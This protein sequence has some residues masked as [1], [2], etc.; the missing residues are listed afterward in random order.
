MTRV[1]CAM[2]LAASLLVLTP[3]LFAQSVTGPSV[4]TERFQSWIVSCVATSD[5]QDCE[6]IQNIADQ[7]GRPIM[8]LHVSRLKAD[9]PELSM[10]ARFPVNIMTTMPIVWSAGE[11]SVVLSLQICLNTI[12]TAL[13]H[14][15]EDVAA[16]LLR[17]DPQSQTRFAMTQ[18][19]GATVS[20]PLSLT[21]F[22]DAW[23]AMVARTR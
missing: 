7:A 3:Q 2:A 1:F 14:I 18:A 13:G 11:S 23:K 10:L 6:I 19:S 4:K 9:D 15:S 5:R 12:C 22:A 20:F 17:A 16:A 8:Q 21:G